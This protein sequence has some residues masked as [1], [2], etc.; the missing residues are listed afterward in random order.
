[1]GISIDIALV[2][3]LV[4][5]GIALFPTIFNLGI[6]TAHASQ[7]AI[8]QPPMPVNGVLDLEGYR[9]DQQGALALQGEWFL[10]WDKLLAPK[11]WA[12]IVTET[13]GKMSVPGNWNSPTR[14]DAFT[15]S[16]APISAVGK[17][18]YL[19]RVINHRGPLPGFKIPG[20]S[21]AAR[22]LYVTNEG[23]VF[24]QAQVGFTETPPKPRSP[25][26]MQL[27]IWNLRRRQ[28][29]HPGPFRGWLVC[30]A[31]CRQLPR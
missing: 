10:S 21:S 15:D 27:S 8:G 16:S 24:A 5:A 18:T 1:M 3:L 26:H 25:F 29:C 4:C 28:S 19:L 9:I 31:S 14:T 7:A 6:S 11:P 17:A 2:R 12:V 13:T 22:V 30:A 20:V 23:E